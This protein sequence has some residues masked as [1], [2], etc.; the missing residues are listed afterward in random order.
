MCR[1]LF[2][3]R[4]GER[5]AC[6]VFVLGRRH[7]SSGSQKPPPRLRLGWGFGCA[8]A[9]VSAALAVVP[10][11][12]GGFLPE[13]TLWQTRSKSSRSSRENVS[14]SSIGFGG[15]LFWAALPF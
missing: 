5:A 1:M 9:G 3:E 2:R 15:G 10:P 13:F 4:R 14:H 11:F 6:R 8:S 12:L 7:H